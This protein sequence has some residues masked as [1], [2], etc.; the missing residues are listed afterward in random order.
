MS[1]KDDSA[2]KRTIDR[3]AKAAFLSA[4]RAG[5]ARDEAARQA[6]F[7]SQAFYGARKRD[8]VFKLGW[9]W[10]LELSA[11]EERETY[12]PASLHD[13]GRG[14]DCG[15]DG[16][17]I[18]PNNKRVL[19]KRRVRS[20]RFGAARR[21]I[22]LDHFAGTADLFASAEAAGVHYSTVYRHLAQDPQFAE[23][24]KATLR[25]SY[26]L[27]EAEALRQR[28][29]A[30][31]QIREAPQPTGKMAKEFERVMQLLAR[32][33]RR[34]GRIGMRTV[35]PGRQKRV[36]FD[37]AIRVLDK[38]LRALGLRHGIP[39]NGEPDKAE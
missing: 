31:R 20:V 7:S 38:R 11:I 13:G 1:G 35:A 3:Q 32:L 4:L 14:T 18:T 28:L 39:D 30:Q 36:S 9:I 22:F 6:G 29:E 34:D 5:G 8:P 16:V 19:Q 27:L 12:R 24:A 33:D 23:A 17:E 37:E 26:V 25:Q 10:A 2:P 15:P 21:K